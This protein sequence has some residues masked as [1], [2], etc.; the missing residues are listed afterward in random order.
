MTLALQVPSIFYFFFYIGHANSNSSNHGKE[1][2]YQANIQMYDVVLL[3]GV[4]WYA[5]V[6][7]Q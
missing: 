2:H 7:S 5:A 1:C 6:Q 3:K 4:W